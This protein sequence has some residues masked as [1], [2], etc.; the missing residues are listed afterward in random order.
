MLMFY[1][2]RFEG[3]FFKERAVI[4]H[5]PSTIRNAVRF[6]SC[7]QLISSSTL[8]RNVPKSLVNSIVV[9]LQEQL[10]L[11]HDVVYASGDPARYL[12]FLA[13]GT[14]AVFLSTGEEVGHL[15]DN[16]SFGEMGLMLR[17]HRHRHLESVVALEV[18]EI[19]LLER[20]DFERLVRPLPRLYN[21]IRAAAMLRAADVS[22]MEWKDAYNGYDRDYSFENVRPTSP[23]S[24]TSASTEQRATSKRINRK[25]NLNV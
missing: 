4:A 15:T 8:F 11:P 1:S 20:R 5:L 25:K 22:L 17:E 19:Y 2:H 9:A 14:V 23:T 16:A 6:A 7:R 3:R 10:F 18:C 24:S 21:R 13:Q 12:H